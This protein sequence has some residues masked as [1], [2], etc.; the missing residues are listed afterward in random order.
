ML[1]SFTL[2]P[3]RLTQYSPHPYPVQM[4]GTASPAYKDHSLVDSP[5][6]LWLPRDSPPQDWQTCQNKVFSDCFTEVPILRKGKLRTKRVN[7]LAKANSQPGSEVE[8]QLL[9]WPCVN[10]KRWAHCQSSTDISKLTAPWPSVQVISVFE[11]NWGSGK[12]S[13]LNQGSQW[14]KDRVQICSLNES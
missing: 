2:N 12:K 7:T 4:L 8:G 14:M 10:Y 5:H 9:H 1:C 3:Q 13:K 11:V 6:Y